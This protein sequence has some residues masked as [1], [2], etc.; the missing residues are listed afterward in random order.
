MRTQTLAVVL[1]AT[2]MLAGCGL[3]PEAA[4]APAV[5]VTET[6]PPAATSPTVSPSTAAPV[7]SPTKT[8]AK[9]VRVPSVVGMNH[10]KAQNLLQSHGLFMLREEDAT[11][12][13]RLLLWDRN[14]V[15]VRQS[16][17]AGTRVSTEATITL[18]SK[19]IGE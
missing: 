9:R 2:A 13:N 8:V 17:R 11:G 5:T 14:W 4:P 19:K 6:A 12:Q 7:P 16:P 10:Q 1:A 18:F 3:E 15:V